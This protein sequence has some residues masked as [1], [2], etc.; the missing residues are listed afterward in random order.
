MILKKTALLAV[1]AAFALCSCGQAS[2]SE[3]SHSSAETTAAP[4]ATTTP[5]AEPA[6][7]EMTS[8]TTTETTT[9]AAEEVSSAEETSEPESEPE[10]EAEPEDIILETVLFD[11][12]SGRNVARVGCGPTSVAMILVSEKQLDITKDDAVELAYSRGFYYWAG[13]NFTSGFGATQENMQQLFAAYGFQSTIDHLWEEDDEAVLDKIDTLLSEGHRIMLGHCRADGVL[14]YAVI[15]GRRTSSG[16]ISYLIN[17]PQGGFE[18][19]W[20]AEELL[21]SL[22]RTNAA[23]GS[24]VNGLVKG[25]QWISG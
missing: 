12:L 5:K 1:L 17:D 13:E 19:Q 21:E 18:A 25:I 4:P 2:S 14:H 16:E 9:T 7:A 6:D 24:T 10:S 15:F 11:Q 20:T 3:A 22:H 8:Q 23:D